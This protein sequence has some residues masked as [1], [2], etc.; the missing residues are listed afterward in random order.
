MGKPLVADSSEM[1]PRSGMTSK[2]RLIS[3]LLFGL[4]FI[5]GCVVA[6]LTDR[7]QLILSSPREDAQLG[8]ILM[9]KAGY[10]PRQ[11][12]IVWERMAKEKG[13]RPPEFFSTHPNPETRIKDFEGW[14]P[15]ALAHYEK[16]KKPEEIVVR[17]GEDY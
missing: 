4:L 3:A 7:Q 9:A 10:D 6:P 8:V 11:A 12:F 2:R 17:A 16:V 1:E 13:P 5:F 15:E 14:M